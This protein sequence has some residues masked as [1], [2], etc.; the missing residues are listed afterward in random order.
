MLYMFVCLGVGRIFSRRCTSGFFQ[1]FFLGGAKSGEI[2]FLSLETK[3]T[4]FFAKIFK[5]LPPSYTHACM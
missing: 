3:K 5:F 2:W 4:A 1:K